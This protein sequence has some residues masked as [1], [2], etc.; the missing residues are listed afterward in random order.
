MNRNRIKSNLNIFSLVNVAIILSVINFL[1]PSKYTL[2]ILNVLLRPSNKKYDS[3][4]PNKLRKVFGAES[5]LNELIGPMHK[6]CIE[7]GQV[8]QY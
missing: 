1:N 4:K 3:K 2:N 7:N 8:R 5:H 6:D